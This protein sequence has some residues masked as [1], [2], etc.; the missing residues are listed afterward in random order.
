MTDSWPDQTTIWLNWPS[1]FYSVY[2]SFKIR[3]PNRHRN[4]A[5]AFKG[6]KPGINHEKIDGLNQAMVERFAPDPGV[7][8]YCLSSAKK[9]RWR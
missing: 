5:V 9:P 4:H 7:D 6:P 2:L 3:V 1:F 8:H